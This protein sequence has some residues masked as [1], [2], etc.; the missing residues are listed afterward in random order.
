MPLANNQRIALVAKDTASLLQ[1][2]AMLA[3]SQQQ[4]IAAASVQLEK[5][6]L[7]PDLSLAYNN[8]SIQGVGADNKLYSSSQRFSSVQ[9][10]VGIPI[11]ARAQ[12]EKI[13]SAKFSNQ[14]AVN[15]F[16]TSLQLLKTEYQ[17]AFIQYKK[18]LETVQYFETYVLK[19]AALI[20]ET[21]NLQLGNGIIN[22]LEWVQLI[23]QATT[24]KN[25][26]LEAERN[27]NEAIIQLNYFTNK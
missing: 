5:S 22:Y 1:H 12:K 4:Q 25:E 23:S 9:L 8:I 3:I 18:Y 14:L 13:N 27:L 17:T 20:T 19:N 21:A 6:R 16:S 11:F 10:G 7:L 24:V 26:Y 15:N 2:P